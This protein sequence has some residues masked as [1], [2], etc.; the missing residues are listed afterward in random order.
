MNFTRETWVKLKKKVNEGAPHV[1]IDLMISL[2]KNFTVK[3]A[4]SH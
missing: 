2:L 3:V 1:Y 4:T